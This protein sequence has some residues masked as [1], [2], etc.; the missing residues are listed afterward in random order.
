MA[1]SKARQAGTGSKSP[2][3]GLIREGWW[4]VVRHPVMGPGMWTATAVNF[5]CG[6][7]LAVYPLYLVRELHAPA[8]LVGLLL[9]LF[10][11]AVLA[12][13][14]V[15]MLSPIRRLRDL[16]DFR[17]DRRAVDESLHSQAT[18]DVGHV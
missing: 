18:V 5:V 16:T 1:G 6:A 4:F 11:A 10:A 13:P 2:T 8:V 14:L 7:Q 15:L 9:W 3:R 17:P 12:A